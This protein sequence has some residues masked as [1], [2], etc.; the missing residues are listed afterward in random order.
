MRSGA[1]R[2]KEARSWLLMLRA[3]RVTVAPQCIAA[4]GKRRG[5]SPHVPAGA[6]SSLRRAS[7]LRLK[8]QEQ[9]ESRLRVEGGSSTATADRP[10]LS[11]LPLAD[12]LSRDTAGGDDSETYRAKLERRWQQQLAEPDSPQSSEQRVSIRRRSSAAAS[13]VP[14]PQ[15]REAGQRLR[16]SGSPGPSGREQQKSLSGSRPARAAAQPQQAVSGPPKTSRR[17]RSAMPVLVRASSLP[18]W[19]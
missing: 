13:T 10:A 14:R 2:N 17:I 7:S 5:T 1:P 16:T 15:Q 8:E 9:T 6:A 18:G 19:R 11:S 4:G 3:S 12:V